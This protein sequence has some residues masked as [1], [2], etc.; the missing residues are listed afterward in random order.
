MSMV[1]REHR[2]PREVVDALFLETCKVRWDAT[3]SHLISLEV[4]LLIAGL[5]G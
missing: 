4:F 1:K 5:L 3:L 2:L